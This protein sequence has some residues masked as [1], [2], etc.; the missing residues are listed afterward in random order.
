LAGEKSVRS[1][2]AAAA[3][4]FFTRALLQIERSGKSA[5]PN[6]MLRIRSGRAN[7]LH[8]MGDIQASLRDY[9]EAIRIAREVGNQQIEMSC[10]AEVPFLLYN[11]ALKDHVPRFC[12]E[13]LTLARALG[14]KGAES[15]ILYSQAYWRYLWLGS[16]EHEAFQQA[17]DIA[18]R[19]GQP[20]A[21]VFTK[22]LSAIIDRW[23]GNPQHSL[24]ISEGVT[25]LLQSIFNVILAGLAAF[26]R[27]MALTDSG[28]YDEAI[29]STTPWIDMFE[30]TSNNLLLGRCTNTLAWTYSEIC[31]FQKAVE[32]NH[33]SLEHA[34]GL[35]KRPA[36]AFTAAEMRAHAEVNLMENTFAIGKKAGAWE[37]LA[38]F[39]EICAHPDYDC[40]RVRWLTRMND[41][42]GTMLLEKGDLDGAEELAKGCL[43]IA[44]K[45]RY[46]K[47]VGK[48]QR[49][50][51]QV[52]TARGAHDLAE[53]KLKSA[54]VSLEEVGNPKQLRL[55]RTALARL[56]GKMSRP[57]LERTEWQ[58]AAAVV[59]STADGLTD[60][61][62]RGT[63]LG[64]AP[65]REIMGHVA[66]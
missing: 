65:V 64:A 16:D 63:F 29:R 45:K 44:T 17:H 46:R 6:L 10:L 62:L 18:E 37:R 30:R 42:K 15:R 57:D 33:R 47:Y 26:A 34:I 11:T 52:L 4:D 21:I 1:Q 22:L 59:R 3:A 5:D 8:A 61:S 53:A 58:A 36:L 12:E 39:E 50:L 35:F 19:S 49:L 60:R 66:R 14:D 55:T 28:R 13:G 9:E 2:A 27:S 24:E 40:S 31:D 38:K 51:G 43:D 41:L 56:Y 54:L 7:P 20:A 48:A 23:N 32:L 25:E